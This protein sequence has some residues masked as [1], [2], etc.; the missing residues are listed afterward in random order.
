MT[1]PSALPHETEV[2]VDNQVEGAL[3]R[4][5]AEVSKMPEA[6]VLSVSARAGRLT[7]QG[8]DTSGWDRVRALPGVLIVR[9]VHHEPAYAL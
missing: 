8:G 1:L 9:R 5:N 2:L 4:V 3:E 7:A 6:V